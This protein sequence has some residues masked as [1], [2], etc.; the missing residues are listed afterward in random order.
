MWYDNLSDR[1]LWEIFD[2]ISGIPRES[3]NEEGIRKFLLRWA[4]EHGLAN[5]TDDIG[6]VFIYAPATSGHEHVPAVALQGHMDMV[7]VKRPGSM[8]DFTKDPIEIVCENGIIH[9]KDTS[10][11]ADNGIAIAIALSIFTDPTAEH[12]PLEAIFT[13]SEETGLTGAFNLDAGKVKARRM[14]NLD[15]EEESIIYIGCAGG[16]DM[17][18]VLPLKKTPN[19]AA[20]TY[21]IKVHGLLGG[22]SGGEIH[23]ERGNAVK[24]LA[25]ILERIGRYSLVS[26][27]G[28]TKHNVIPSEAVATISASSDPTAKVRKV[29]KEIANE[30]KYADPGFEATVKEIDNVDEVLSAKT[31]DRI[32]DLLFTAPHGVK[33]MSTAIPG[34]VETSNNLAIVKTGKEEFVIRNSIRSNIGSARDNHLLMLTTL[35]KAYGFSVEAGDGYPEWEP[36]PNSKFLKIVANAYKDILGNEPKITAIHAGLECGIINKRIKGMDSI[37]IGPDLLDVHSVNEHVVAE[38]AERISYFIRELLAR[39]K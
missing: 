8:H 37:S 11:G 39:M 19:K 26:I 17:K 27:D 29:A 6:N 33:T 7:C 2:E 5:D 14:I 18:A 21:E 30:L 9:A 34:I 1:R 16:V 38:S 22:H 3:G 24:L 13:I 36:D 15:S 35:Y 4:D 25:R 23:K 12:G 32:V 20:H 31:R 28:G 10:L